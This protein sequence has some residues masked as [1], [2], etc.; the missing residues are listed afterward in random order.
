[1]TSAN[2]PAPPIP[3][4]AWLS[5]AFSCI[6]VASAIGAAL[7]SERENLRPYSLLINTYVLTA[8]VSFVL[9]L[10]AFGNSLRTSRKVHLLSWLAIISATVLF[11]YLLV[12][13]IGVL[14]A[15]SNCPRG[16]C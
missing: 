14:W 16:V 12:A 15:Y 5:I 7:V 8:P 13:M 10:W 2:L 11:G 4:L 9:A 6:C 3:R 1:V